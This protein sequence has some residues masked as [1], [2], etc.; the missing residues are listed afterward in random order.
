MIGMGLVIQSY[1]V[2][3]NGCPLTI[4]DEGTDHVA[5]RCGGSNGESFEIVIEH[6]ALRALVK[7][8]ED[9]LEDIDPPGEDTSPGGLRGSLPS[10]HHTPTTNEVKPA[11]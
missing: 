1:I 3:N 10:V 11:S 7:L 2:I 8:G 6:N 9:K 5:I 4:A